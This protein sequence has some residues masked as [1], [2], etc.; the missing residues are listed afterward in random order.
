[1]RGQPRRVVV[2]TTAWC[3]DCRRAK[4]YLD[5][6]GVAY[7]EVD[8]ER[9]PEAAERVVQWSGG[10]RT[11]PTFDIDGQIIVDWDRRAVARALG[12]DE[13]ASGRELSDREASP[14]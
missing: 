3:G 14:A 6:H 13:G 8:I 9:D 11:V 5:E 2:Y 12:L 4:R 10:C 1:M 7:E